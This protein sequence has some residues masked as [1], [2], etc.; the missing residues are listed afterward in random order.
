[1]PTSSK[2][3]TTNITRVGLLNKN[4]NKAE[5]HLTNLARM[6]THMTVQV[7]IASKRL[8][9]P[10]TIERSENKSETFP[11]AQHDLL[12]SCMRSTMACQT[13]R[14]CETLAALITRIGFL[15]FFLF[16]RKSDQ[17]ICLKN[18]SPSN[19]KRRDLPR[20]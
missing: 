15:F 18:E 10:R 9:T 7:T 4:K 3:L 11:Q 16:S 14:V 5:K 2:T 12:F 17:T 19:L 13:T 1:M 6:D 8:V 20:I